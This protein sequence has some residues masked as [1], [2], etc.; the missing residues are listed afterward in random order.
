LILQD[1][2]SLGAYQ[3]GVLDVLYHWIKKDCYENDNVFDIITGTLIG[4][5][6]A[7]KLT[8]HTHLNNRH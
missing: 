5:I 3:V 6:N 2:G 8:S 1:G 4:P 7:A